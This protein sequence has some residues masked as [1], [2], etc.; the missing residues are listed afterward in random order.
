V[1]ILKLKGMCYHTICLWPVIVLGLSRFYWFRIFLYNSCV[2]VAIVMD[3]GHYSCTI[4]CHG[5]TLAH[6]LNSA[7]LQ[8]SLSSQRL[9]KVL[10]CSLL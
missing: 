3:V 7:R 10:C 4:C 5:D 8:S 2:Q 1:K 9:K 6:T